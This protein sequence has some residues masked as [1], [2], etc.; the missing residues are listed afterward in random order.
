V[1]RGLPFQFTT[2]LETKPVPF[3]VSVNA[4]PPGA[5]ASG[6]SGWLIRGT[7][8]V[9]AI[10]EDAKPIN[11]SINISAMET[12]SNLINIVTLL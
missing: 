12:R 2:D 11:A 7:G 5:T 3:T 1:A 8:L 10:A 4:G 9:F 6:T